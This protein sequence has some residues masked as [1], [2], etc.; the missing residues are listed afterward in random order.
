MPDGLILHQ[1]AVT[2]A[3]LQAFP[4][5]RDGSM[6]V[7]AAVA[8]ISFIAPEKGGGAPPIE[9]HLVVHTALLGRD[10]R[11]YYGLLRLFRLL[12]MGD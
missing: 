1:R 5:C 6:Y 4:G 8:W 12:R 7:C 9:E 10:D 11:Y 3:A 2:V